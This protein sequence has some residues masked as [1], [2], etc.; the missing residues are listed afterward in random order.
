MG[1]SNDRN[2]GGE[3]PHRGAEQTSIDQRSVGHNAS[4]SQS[5]KAWWKGGI[6]YV[7]IQLPVAIG[8]RLANEM[9]DQRRIR[10]LSTQQSP[11]EFDICG[12][13]RKRMQR[14]CAYIAPVMIQG[15]GRRSK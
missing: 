3:T 12:G 4:L 13:V 2:A 14:S 6:N 5:T 10:W 7:V 11:I 8:T 1:R 15:I 9:S